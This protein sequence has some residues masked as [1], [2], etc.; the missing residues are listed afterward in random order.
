M[1]NQ[2]N[3]HLKALYIQR[4]PNSLIKFDS[5]FNCEKMK[6]NQYERN[7]RITGTEVASN[8]CLSLCCLPVMGW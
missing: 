7:M 2:S 3:G 6:R 1:P 8:A 5:G 4:S